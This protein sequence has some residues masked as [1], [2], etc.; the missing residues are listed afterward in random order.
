MSFCCA[1]NV[2]FREKIATEVQTKPLTKL[3]LCLALNAAVSRASRAFRANAL[4]AAVS[5]ECIHSS[6]QDALLRNTVVNREM[7]NE[8][9]S[10]KEASILA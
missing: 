10:N 3:F 8:S 9:R 7:H 1:K 5:I 6:R 4:D 2:V